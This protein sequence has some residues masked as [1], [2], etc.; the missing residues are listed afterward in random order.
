[1]ILGVFAP[2]ERSVCEV[3]RVPKSLSGITFRCFLSSLRISPMGKLLLPRDHLRRYLA[4]SAAVWAGAV[5]VA[6]R[7]G[8]G[9]AN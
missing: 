8:C 6:D 1:M 3:G 7:R 2:P 5:V 4:H 9:T